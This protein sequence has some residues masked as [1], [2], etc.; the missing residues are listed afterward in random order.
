MKAM[1]LAAGRGARL[2]PLTDSTPKPL[3]IAHGK[4]LIAYHIERLARAGVRQLVINTSWLGEKIEA[5]VGDGSRFGVEVL[6]SREPQ[7]L[8]TGGGIR[9]A[10]PLLGHDPF[11]VV[12]SDIWTDYP[13]EK[14][15]AQDWSAEQDAYLVLVPNPPHHQRGD[16]ILDAAGV[17]RHSRHSAATLT[18]SGI[19]ILW[20]EIFALHPWGSEKFALRDVLSGSIDAGFVNGECYHGNW[21]DIGTVERLQALDLFLN[22]G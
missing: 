19:S 22:A 9:R 4:P 14:L 1:I 18:F 5:Y 13:F 16:F 17:V 8:E 10:L 15:V 7:P 2:R 3:L 21:W 6:W 12:N 11:L 20:P